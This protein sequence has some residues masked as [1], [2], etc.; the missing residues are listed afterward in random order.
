MEY[1]FFQTYGKV[2][3]QLFTSN[4]RSDTPVFLALTT[5]ELTGE[6]IKQASDHIAH[7][8]HPNE[9]RRTRETITYLRKTLKQEQAEQEIK[10]RRQVES[11]ANASYYLREFSK[12]CRKDNETLLHRNPFY[13]LAKLVFR[14]NL[15]GARNLLHHNQSE[16]L[17]HIPERL[18]FFATNREIW[19]R[20]HFSVIS[21]GMELLGK[22]IIGS[23]V[24]LVL[25]LTLLSALMTGI[26]F[27]G[28]FHDHL[29]STL[30]LGLFGDG[31]K[32]EISIMTIGLVLGLFL[33]LLILD[34]KSRLYRGMA[35]TG[36][37]LSGIRHAF[38]KHPIWMIIALLCTLLS[39]KSNFDGINT[40]LFKTTHVNQ[41][42]SRVK[43]N[44]ETVLGD[45][46][47][48]GM[49]SLHSRMV[50]L[51]AWASWVPVVFQRIADVQNRV[52]RR[53][54]GRSR[55]P[56]MA[57]VDW[58]KQ[59][60]VRGGYQPGVNDV[61]NQVG[62]RRGGQ[63]QDQLLTMQKEVDLSRSITQKFQA[64]LSQYK[65]HVTRTDAYVKTQLDDLEQLF[66][67]AEAGH[68]R[69]LADFAL[70]VSLYQ[71]IHQGNQIIRAILDALQASET[72]YVQAVAE[73]NHIINNSNALLLK[74]DP[75][76]FSTI[77][78]KNSSA[79]NRE[80]VRQAVQTITVLASLPA[81]QT[82]A[83]QRLLAADSV[84]LAAM[85]ES[86]AQ[87]FG[88]GTAQYLLG[89]MI[90]LAVA[91][92]MGEF[93][94]FSGWITWRGRQDRTQIE[95]RLLVLQKWEALFVEQA[96]TFFA[97]EDV[98]H[99]LPGI[100]FPTEISNHNA[101]HLVVE[102]SSSKAKDRLDQSLSEKYRAWFKDLFLPARMADMVAY[103]ARVYA[104]ELFKRN[105][106]G[107]LSRWVGQILPGLQMDRGLGQQ[108]F[109]DLQ[110]NM[111]ECLS[112]NRQ[113][114]KMLL[115]QILRGESE[116]VSHWAREQMMEQKRLH[117]GFQQN[118]DLQQTDKM[119]QK[120]KPSRNEK[121]VLQ[122]PQVS[123]SVKRV[124]VQPSGQW[125]QHWGHSPAYSRRTWLKEIA[126]NSQN[127]REGIT[128]LYDF[129]PTLKQTLTDT[130]PNLDKN[131]FEPLLDIFTRLPIRCSHAG[132]V[133]IDTLQEQ[134]QQLE[135]LAV[136][137]LGLSEILDPEID[138]RT[139]N[140]L[141]SKEEVEH[142]AAIVQ[143]GKNKEPHFSNQLEHLTLGLQTT[144][145]KAQAVELQLDMERKQQITALQA[146]TKEL[147]Q[148]LT[149]IN[150][151]GWEARKKRPPS[152]DHLNILM[153]NKGLFEQAPKELDVLIK[154]AQPLLAESPRESHLTH[155]MEL[156]L[157][158]QILVDNANEVLQ[159]LEKPTHVDRRL[160]QRLDEE[161]PDDEIA[162]QQN[163]A[164][165]KSRRKAEREAFT[166]EVELI[167]DQGHRYHGTSADISS[168]GIRMIP[169][170]AS[171]YLLKGERGKLHLLD[172]PNRTPFTC[173][174]VQSSENF[175]ALHLVHKIAEFESLVAKLV[176][177][178]VQRPS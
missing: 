134:F 75:K 89:M 12:A 23:K 85:E 64:V 76:I 43:S 15:S 124:D 22:G 123:P 125:F 69:P 63:Q 170:V 174:V 111:E 104:L 31:M 156:I 82:L 92:D 73:L 175:I 57:P 51:D 113:G 30:S 78:A 130:L 41:Q 26:A 162:L 3:E 146:K 17:K 68:F 138:D 118:S 98:Q 16:L 59:F 32:S 112:Q 44:I 167:T 136:E 143:G 171:T 42:A 141:T 53:R 35:E 101:L 88:V 144:L 36:T 99:I 10:G 79:Q 94:L 177:K 163:Q 91:L 74:V 152:H 109:S 102:A 168:T 133:S 56:R 67:P 155:L 172:D 54:V 18:P 70:A 14:H 5:E 2:V 122:K 157:K 1:S 40:M 7:H 131:V 52:D 158:A 48:Q 148:V 95:N 137:M 61:V 129:R 103:N 142:M 154:Q 45:V 150:M 115:Q 34:F 33:A 50:Q 55:A 86:L 37:V 80:S 84:T 21:R 72:H 81:L 132:F 153:A 62:R 135:K 97:R 96:M 83:N 47:L 116:A 151:R 46:Y 169:S 87:Q 60:I 117:K 128:L 100:T 19:T 28:H 29:H 121:T 20:Q 139:L 6:R 49:D 9:L 166:T 38:V 176:M 106:D 66:S 126:T 27:Y 58:A 25:A 127:F 173:H 13:E 145:H 90:L 165:E 114:F 39:I 71:R 159:A 11:S 178:E 8:I 105:P 107:M 24:S 119:V 149:Q 77:P 120:F 108:M 161:S 147:H 140:T 65:I 110:R 93:L 160:E 164:E 4:K